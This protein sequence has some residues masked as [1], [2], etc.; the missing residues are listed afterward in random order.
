[1]KWEKYVTRILLSTVRVLQLNRDAMSDSEL[2][3]QQG[4]QVV[5][6]LFQYVDVL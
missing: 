3:F 5:P 1:M 6:A 2:A 4:I